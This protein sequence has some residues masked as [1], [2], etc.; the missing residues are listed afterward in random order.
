MS[1]HPSAAGIGP[2]VAIQP[3]RLS[4]GE[5]LSEK[6]LFLTQP[7][8]A[9]PSGWNYSGWIDSYSFLLFRSNTTYFFAIAVHR[10]IFWLAFAQSRSYQ[11][12]Y[13]IKTSIRIS[14]EGF[15]ASQISKTGRCGWATL[16]G[17]IDFARGGAELLWS[18]LGKKVKVLCFSPLPSGVHLWYFTLN[19]LSIWILQYGVSLKCFLLPDLRG[20][21]SWFWLNI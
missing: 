7:K 18:S 6:A 16:H 17:G 20:Y 4:S 3:L 8:S 2:A 5:T 13:W 1:S 9:H 12:I 14:P 19:T 11:Q 10:G 15:W 21:K